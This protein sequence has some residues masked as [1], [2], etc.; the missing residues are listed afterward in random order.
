[1]GTC[2]LCLITC[3]EL[4]FQVLSLILLLVCCVSLDQW[5]C[6]SVPF[7]PVCDPR[8]NIYSW[9][10][11][12]SENRLLGVSRCLPKA[13]LDGFGCWKLR[14]RVPLC[15]PVRPSRALTSP[16]P[17]HT[18]SFFLLFFQS[19]VIEHLL[20]PR[21]CTRLQ[22][23]TDAEAYVAPAHVALPGRLSRRRVRGVLKGP[24]FC[25]EV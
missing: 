23:H 15:M 8:T 1:M 3:P 14:W 6:L 4:D 25:G 19:I 16:G 9:E 11:S 13:G 5:L 17:R 10:F 2:P 20:C 21:H 22:E 7:L 12:A 18:W 24:S